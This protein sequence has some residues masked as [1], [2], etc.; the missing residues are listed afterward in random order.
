MFDFCLEGYKTDTQYKNIFTYVKN[1]KLK[2]DK[3]YVICEKNICVFNLKTME[4]ID[5][6]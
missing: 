5:D 1:V 2:K 4:N 6:T 3:I